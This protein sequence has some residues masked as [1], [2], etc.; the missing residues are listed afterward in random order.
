MYLLTRVLRVVILAA[1]VTHGLLSPKTT[2]SRAVVQQRVGSAI[3]SASSWRDQRWNTMYELM[4]QY[5]E[6]EGHCRVPSGHMENGE[7]LGMWLNRQRQSMKRGKMDETRR[8]TLEE[9]GVSWNPLE[10]NW[11]EMFALLVK[12]KERQGHCRVP[13]RH[14]ENGQALGVWLKTQRASMKRGKMEETRRLTLKVAGVSW[15]PLEDDWEELFALLVKFKEREGHANVNQQKKEDGRNLGGW[16]KNQRVKRKKGKL[17]ESQEVRLT[18]LGIFFDPRRDLWE[19]KFN[20]LMQYKEQ[21]GHCNIL[22][23]HKSSKSLYKWLDCQRQARRAGTLSL[24]GEQKLEEIGVVWNPSCNRWELMFDLLTRYKGKFGHCNV[25]KDHQEEGQNLGKWLAHQRTRKK[26]TNNSKIDESRARRLEDI[27]V[28]W[29]PLDELWE[30][31]FVLFRQ[32]I[33][34]NGHFHVPFN[35]LIGEKDLGKWVYSQWE[36]RVHGRLDSDRFEKLY[37]LGIRWEEDP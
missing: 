3:G 29:A 1:A 33:Q 17:K 26:A 16:L 21:H 11:E 6:R 31:Y 20:M 5:I 13:P 14:M 12:F 35:Y 9:V 18:E 27:G 36:L 7:A 19:R 32:Y 24:F 2:P 37:E 4:L 10:D 22:K 25:P 8:Q 30:S 34:E 23:R 28:S 15:N